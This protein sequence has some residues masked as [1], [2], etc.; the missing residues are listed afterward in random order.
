MSRIHESAAVDMKTV[1]KEKCGCESSRVDCAHSY[2]TR[3]GDLLAQRIPARADGQI[4]LAIIGVYRAPK[5]PEYERKLKWL[6]IDFP[7]ARARRDFERRFEEMK[8]IYRKQ[9]LDHDNDMNR[10]RMG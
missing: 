10:E 6:H 1:L 3:S 5:E 2:I 7:S 9:R 4:N 8:A